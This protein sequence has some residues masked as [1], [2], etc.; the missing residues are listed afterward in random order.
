MTT[1][2][3]VSDRRAPTITPWENIVDRRP[4]PSGSS[5]PTPGHEGA[6]TCGYILPQP[7]G[8]IL[9][10]P[11]AVHGRSVTMNALNRGPAHDLHDA[12]DSQ[13]EAQNWG[14]REDRGTVVGTDVHSPIARRGSEG[15]RSEEF[16]RS[17]SDHVR[18]PVQ[19]GRSKGESRCLGCT[20]VHID[21][22]Y[23]SR[24]E[25]GSIKLLGVL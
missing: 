10:I 22:Y 2:A 18:G 9:T 25:A 6:I 14:E 1:T 5:I 7:I 3:D 13:P 16:G 20:I 17:T 23:K 19:P 11:A 4:N 8:P 24:R 12:T 21:R 15:A